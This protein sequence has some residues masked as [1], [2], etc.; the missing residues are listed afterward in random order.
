[1]TRCR[2][3]RIGGRAAAVGAIAAVAALA[4]A[5]PAAGQS[6]GPLAKSTGHDWPAFRYSAAH[7]GVT[8]QS[9][10]NSS[11]C[12]DPDRRVDGVHRR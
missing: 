11:Q 12:V 4:V 6:A 2:A 7:T 5:L 3:L 10:P 1:M 9:S 8:P